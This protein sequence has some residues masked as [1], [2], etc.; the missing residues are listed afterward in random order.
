MRTTNLR[1]PTTQE[2]YLQ[3]PHSDTCFI[4]DAPAIRDFTHFKIIPNTYPYDAICSEHHMLVPKRH[5]GHRYY[6]NQEEQDELFVILR[7]LEREER[8]DAV[9]QNFTHQKSMTGHEHVHLLVF[10]LK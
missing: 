10:S 9:L 8:Y 3:K 6:F 1:T 2:Q 4:C 7:R 5:V